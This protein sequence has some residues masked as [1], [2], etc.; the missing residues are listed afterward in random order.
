MRLRESGDLL[1]IPLL[2]HII[3][4]ESGYYSFLET[5]DAGLNRGMGFC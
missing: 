2:D 3:F 4:S 5:E 1:G